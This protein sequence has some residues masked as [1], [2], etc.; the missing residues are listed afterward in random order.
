VRLTVPGHCYIREEPIAAA[1]DSLDEAGI[2]RRIAQCFSNLGNCFVEAVIE[3]NDRVRPKLA[4]QFFPGEQLARPFKQHGQQLKR[5]LL[6][7]DA[8]TAL[9]QFARSNIGFKDSKAQSL[10][11]L[12]GSQDSPLISY[13]APPQA[14]R[15][16]VV[17][18][19]FQFPSVFASEDTRDAGFIPEA[20]KK[21][22]LMR[23]A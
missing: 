12:S 10:V 18:D 3:V 8:S 5:L 21:D 16:K 4:T 17:L 13:A 14:A 11:L 1:S 22:L 23:I 19:D 20:N 2:L 7:P 6:Q 9:G 15:V